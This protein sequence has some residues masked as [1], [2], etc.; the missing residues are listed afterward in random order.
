MTRKRKRRGSCHST[1][2]RRDL[3]KSYYF[4]SVSFFS[5]SVFF[6]VVLPAGSFFSVS[7]FFSSFFT[8]GLLSP[9][10]MAPKAR[11]EAANAVVRSFFIVVPL[12]NGLGKGPR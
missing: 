2:G 11:K 10:P 12:R 9:Q 5:V 1:G 3:A 6:S 7:T 4:F 8:A